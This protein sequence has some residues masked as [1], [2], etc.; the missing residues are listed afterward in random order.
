MNKKDIIKQVK[1]MFPWYQCINL[2]GI[3]TITKG[4][5]VGKY[6]NANAGEHTWNT[7]S[8]FLPP[9]LENM[10][11]LDLGCNAGFYSVKSSLLGAKEVIGVEMAPIFLKQAFYIKEFFEKSYN[12]KLNITYIKSNIGDLDWNSMGDFEYV[13]AISVLYH[14]GK[15][16]YGKYTPEALKEQIEV[17]NTL[18]NHTKKFIVRC[19]NSSKNSREYYSNI[20]KQC[21][22]VEKRFIPEGKRGMILYERS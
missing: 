22:F 8:K 9:S 2:D 18:S 12:K 7:I 17:I 19:R 6:F 10:R 20:F 4:G 5:T 21:G 13:F 16:K 3:M 15:H 14:I 1:D 11:I